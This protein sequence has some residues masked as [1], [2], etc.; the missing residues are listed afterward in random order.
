[1]FY[2][3]KLSIICHEILT[4]SV[5]TACHTTQFCNS[6]SDLDCI[7]RFVSVADLMEPL[8]DGTQSQVGVHYW[9]SI[10]CFCTIQ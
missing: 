7:G 2:V 3:L 5:C 10:V 4:K 1:M 9:R 8:D 6:K